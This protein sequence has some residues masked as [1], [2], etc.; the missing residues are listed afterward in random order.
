[1]AAQGLRVL[2][3]ARGRAPDG[4]V[5][6]HQADYT[7]E[8]L[9]LAAFEDPLRA[10]VPAAMAQARAAGIA[11]V[12]ITGDHVGT[13]LAI[14][15]Q[16]GIATGA[17]AMTGA[18]VASMGDDALRAALKDVRVF[19]RV[20]PVQKLRLVQALQ[21][22]GE[23]VAMTGDGVNDAPALKAADVGI[24]MGVRGT[25]VA[26]EAA[27][28]VLLDEEVSRIVQGVRM[29]RR[30]FD[31]LRRAMTYIVAI[32][33]PIAG[34]ALLP[35]VFGL[36]PLLLPA[37]VVLTEMV[38][39]PVC[40]FAFEGV[41]EDPAIMRRP[42]RPP[43]EALLGHGT[44]ARGLVEGVVLLAAALALYAMALRSMDAMQ[45]R[46]VAVVALMVGN[47]TLVWVNTGSHHSVRG[48]AGTALVVIT[49]GASLVVGAAI[50]WPPLRSLLQFG[51]P[52]P[53]ALAVAIL[54]PLAAVL[55]AA[56]GTGRLAGPRP[57]GA[58]GR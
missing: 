23:T 44:L 34:L 49:A 22:N 18:Q 36:P 38:V 12:M 52:S 11:I 37:H 42:P 13:A 57:R 58:T 20:L 51:V 26:R 40:S 1:L 31:N 32:H 33:V 54:A 4:G 50:A 3:V 35:L 8:W 5:A 45:A 53:S 2:G 14:A 19:A 15:R 30:T 6:A 55:A 16:A 41:A 46:T 24:A 25:D 39:D 27:G 48:P 9:G 47:L 28:L 10:D 21:A 29:G 43:R 17:G 7:F 56:G